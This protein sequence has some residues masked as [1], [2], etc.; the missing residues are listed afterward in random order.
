MAGYTSGGGIGPMARTFGAASDRV[1]SFEVVTGDG[2]LH[3]VSA[4]SDPELFWGLRGG[5]GSLG[6]IT[7]MEF[8]LLELPFIYAGALFL[9]H[10]T[11][12][13]CCAPGPNGAPL[14]PA[15]PP[16]P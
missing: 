2:E 5:K 10:S 14:S 8:E 9:T 4:Q 6:I 1:R 7:G 13:T 11:S 15:P 16:P 3:Q 12:K